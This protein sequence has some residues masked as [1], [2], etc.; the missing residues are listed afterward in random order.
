M[1]KLHRWISIVAAVF[2]TVVAITGMLLAMDEIALRLSGRLPKSLGGEASN[3]PAVTATLHAE[4]LDRLLDTTLRGAVQASPNAQFTSL[5]VRVSGDMTQGIVTTGAPHAQ[6]YTFNAQTG[7]RILPDSP[8][9]PPTGY[10]MRWN[11]HQIVKRIHRGDYF[12]FTGR[13]MSVAT[14][15]ALLFLVVSGAVMYLN[16]ARRRWKAG[17]RR[18]F[19]K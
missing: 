4:D 5:W 16:L 6:Q 19:W 10:V 3:A 11:I 9:L 17:Q 12:G 13:W 15:G 18:W 2:L 8:S 14:G 7:E 1:R